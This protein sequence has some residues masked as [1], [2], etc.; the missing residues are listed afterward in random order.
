MKDGEKKVPTFMLRST[1]TLPLLAVDLITEFAVPFWPG[2][3]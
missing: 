2:V 3:V 1:W